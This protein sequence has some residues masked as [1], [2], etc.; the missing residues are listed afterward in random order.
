MFLKYLTNKQ[1]K[2]RDSLIDKVKKQFEITHDS[3]SDSILSAL[4]DVRD[5][6]IVLYVKN[7]IMGAISYYMNKRTKNVEIDHLGVIEQKC[8]YGTILIKEVFRIAKIHKK[9]TVSVVT[10]GY[11]DGFYEKM[12]MIRA[13]N[14]SPAVY[15]LNLKNY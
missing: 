13:N 11:S 4:G 12:N 14:H 5:Y 8:G 10:N 3:G 1:T 2:I 15:E 6:V 9:I 7:N